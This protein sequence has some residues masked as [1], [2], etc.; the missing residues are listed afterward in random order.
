[1]TAYGSSAAWGQS[2]DQFNVESCMDGFPVF[3]SYA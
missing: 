1:M 3:A 2:P